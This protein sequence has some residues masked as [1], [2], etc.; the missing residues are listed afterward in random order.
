[1]AIKNSYKEEFKNI[2][3]RKI[4]LSNE[5]EKYKDRSI[6]IFYGIYNFPCISI[7]IVDK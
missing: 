1:M 3:E 6:N 2:F 4:N 7:I 5:D